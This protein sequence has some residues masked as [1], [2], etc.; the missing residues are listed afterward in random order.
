[1]KHACRFL[2]LLVPALAL[3]VVSTAPAPALAG[4]SGVKASKQARPGD[5]ASR[6]VLERDGDLFRLVNGRKCQVTNDVVDFK[7]SQHPSDL[8]VIYYI[9][10]EGPRANLYV[11]HNTDRRG[12]CPKAKKLEIMAD[13]ARDRGK[14]RYNVVS[15]TDSTAVSMALSRRG[16][17]KVWSRDDTLIEKRRIKDYRLHDKYGKRGAPFSRYVAFALDRRGQLFKVDGKRPR[18]S[19]YDRSQRYRR[20]DD[21]FRTQLAQR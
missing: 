3:A 13:V 9:R 17:F 12:D 10:Q 8:A 14:Y 18:T 4:P 6:Y 2:S 1:M 16:V 7:V 19:S 20:L 21:F 5:V 11:L 15:S